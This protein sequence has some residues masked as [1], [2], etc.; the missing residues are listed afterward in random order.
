MF[1]KVKRAVK[2][3]AS[4]VKKTVKSVVSAT[5]SMVNIVKRVIERTVISVAERFT[6]WVASIGIRMKELAEW[7]GDHLP[8][9]LGKWAQGALEFL[10][11]AITFAGYA[12]A[13]QLMY[14]MALAIWSPTLLRAADIMLLSAVLALGTALAHI[15]GDAMKILQII[16]M[17]LSYFFPLI[18]LIVVVVVAL[19]AA[20]VLYRVKEHSIPQFEKMEPESQIAMVRMWLS[21]SMIPE[22]MATELRKALAQYDSAMGTQGSQHESSLIMISQMPDLQEFVEFLYASVE[23]D[24]DDELTD[25]PDDG[26]LP[27]GE[28]KP[29]SKRIVSGSIFPIL[30]IGV[31]AWGGYRLSRKR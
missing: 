6:S 15:S 3:V 18:M 24:V 5:K 1:K 22:P 29:P 26:V 13:S 4:A 27:D 17:V 25:A 31:T 8:G 20:A 14:A 21:R 12:I 9:K 30:L 7:V 11:A 19:V 2:K 23:T 10:S 16:L 28:S